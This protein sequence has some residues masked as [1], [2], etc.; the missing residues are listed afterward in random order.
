M[1]QPPAG[2]LL[3]A[4]EEA[5]G[6]LEGLTPAIKYSVWKLHMPHLFTVH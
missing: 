1:E 2:A 3:V 4:L 5:K 6:A